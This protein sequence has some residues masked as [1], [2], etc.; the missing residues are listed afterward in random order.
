MNCSRVQSVE[1]Y[2]RHA[3]LP[4]EVGIRRHRGIVFA[5]LVSAHS[6]H[7]CTQCVCF[8]GMAVLVVMITDSIRRKNATLS[9]SIHRVM[10]NKKQRVYLEY[11][12]E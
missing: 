3:Q 8:V 11:M 12:N 1:G 5:V 10:V 6:R 4:I 2:G 7:T 9:A